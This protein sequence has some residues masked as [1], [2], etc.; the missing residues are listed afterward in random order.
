M[1]TNR[2]RK[3]KQ[4]C[5]KDDLWQN[6][7]LD[8]KNQCVQNGAQCRILHLALPTSQ[9]YYL[10]NEYSQMSTHVTYCWTT[11]QACLT[12]S[13]LIFSQKFVFGV[14]NS[15]FFSSEYFVWICCLNFIVRILFLW[16]LFLF[17][18][19]FH[20]SPLSNSAAAVSSSLCSSSLH[21]SD[22]LF[23]ISFNFA[24]QENF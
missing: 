18:N 6:I 1:T 2:D 7:F 20:C 4:F 22:A 3:S 5:G 13:F 11:L 16:I 10:S 24:F 21:Q 8:M 14:T 19:C 17:L 9:L 12:S 23:R 15:D